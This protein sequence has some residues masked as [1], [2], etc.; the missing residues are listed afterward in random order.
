MMIHTVIFRY[1]W[2]VLLA[3]LLASCSTTR[4]SK[5]ELSEIYNRQAPADKS[6]VYIARPSS[7]GY[8]AKL[9]LSCDG[10]EIG[11]TQGKRFVFTLVAPGTHRFVS[12]GETDE[13]LL[14]VTEAGKTYFIHQQPR[15]GIITARSALETVDEK[16]GREL[17]ARCKL[18]GNCPAY[19]LPK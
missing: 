2:P 1:S 16:T 7:M 17:L 14:L 6:L 9:K 13:E 19:S 18:S 8:L 15:F 12:R 4:L 3:A 5:T 11:F 10:R